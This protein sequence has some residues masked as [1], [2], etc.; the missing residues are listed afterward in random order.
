[1]VVNYLFV[2]IYNVFYIKSFADK[3]MVKFYND[4]KSLKVTKLSYLPVSCHN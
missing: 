2:I 3:C 1:M 4:E